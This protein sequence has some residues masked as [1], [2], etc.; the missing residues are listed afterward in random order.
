MTEFEARL[1]ECLEALSEGR[2][3][4]DECLRRNPEH[5]ASLRPL[6][7]AATMTARAYDV[8]P[9]EEFATAAR[10]R[11]LVATGQRLQEAMDVEPSP[12]FFAAARIRFVMAAQRMK[13]GRAA[14]QR[15]PYRAPVFGSPFRALASGM[16]A[17]VIF[18]GFSTY[19]VASA[20]AAIP[21]DWQY[22]VKLQTERVRVALAFSDEAKRDV[23]LD[24]AEER[25]SEIQQLTK[26]GKII[27]PGVLDRLVEQTQPLIDDA[28]GGDWQPEEAARLEQVS[29]KQQ[30]AL[31]EAAAQIAPAAQDQLTAAVG[32]SKSAQ[33]VSKRI[34]FFDDPLRPPTVL[35]ASVALTATPAPTQTPVTTETPVTTPPAQPDDASSPTP[36]SSGPA[37]SETPSSVIVPQDIVIDSTPAETRQGVKLYAVTAGQVTFLA[38]GSSDGWKLVDAPETGV[39]ALIKFANGDDTS[40]MII[41]TATGD[42]YWYISVNGRFDEVQM[43]ITRDGGVFVADRGV[44]RTAYGDASD[45]PWYVLQSIIRIAPTPTAT[46]ADTA[47]PVASDT[48]AA[49]T[50][51]AKP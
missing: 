20:S 40:L 35:T 14:A 27:G 13:M 34:L 43:R 28:K 29:E 5:A 22:P 41:S 23:K 11:F 1:H 31:E 3:D 6:L 51:T 12:A 36:G 25:V 30:Q 16:A 49:G 2:W 21:G 10:E 47:T 24:I 42:M 9:R 48:A 37:A 7:L 44:L 19:T 46:A 18:L 26:R 8:R 33:E 4:L 45:I 15:Q 50:T 38:P 17:L 39:P 32:V